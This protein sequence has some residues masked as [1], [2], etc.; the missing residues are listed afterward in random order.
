MGAMNS[1]TT[2]RVLRLL[3]V[4]AAAAIVPTLAI[5]APA[6]AASVGGGAYALNANLTAL[7]VPASLGALPT[8]S[9]P[10]DGGG[11]YV[12]S[13]LSTNVLG[14][15]PVQAA[16]V[17]TEGS[18]GRGTVE[19]SA[20][21]LDT[22]VAGLVSVAAA[23]SSC[24]ATTEAATGSATVAG[25]VVAGIPISTVNAGPNTTITLPVGTVTINEQR[26]TG[27]T[28]LTVSAVHVNLT[29][30]IATGDIVIGQSRCVIRS[31][32]RSRTAV[33]RAKSTGRRS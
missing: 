4:A 5:V 6:T 16:K 33:R 11:P 10:P 2:T 27:S 19:S 31:S 25:L 14:L 28:G 26:T 32:T 29:A 8:V 23:R 1:K 22:G 30:A 24:S 20:S 3:G 17:S 15:V 21:A 18:S 12:E 9:L 7:V 13:L